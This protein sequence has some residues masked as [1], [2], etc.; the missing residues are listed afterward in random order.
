MAMVQ[1]APETQKLLNE[2]MSHTQGHAFRRLWQ[3]AITLSQQ[4]KQ[5][6]Q[7]RLREIKKKNAKIKN[8]VK[9]NIL[10]QPEIA[11][12]LGLPVRVSTL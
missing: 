1:L 2:A 3:D 7:N 5:A 8:R 11:H 12:Y 6:M 4:N 10:N 9:I